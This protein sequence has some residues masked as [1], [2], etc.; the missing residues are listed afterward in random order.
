MSFPDRGSVGTDA[1]FDVYDPTVGAV[2][3]VDGLTDFEATVITA[4]L[5]WHGLNGNDAYAYTYRGWS[6]TANY[7]RLNGKLDAYFA[8]REARY[9]SGRALQ[10]VT[11]V[12]TIR[13][14]DGSVSQYRFSKLDLKQ[15]S[16]GRFNRDD[17]VTGTIEGRAGLRE[18]I[19]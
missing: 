14:E 16:S 3:A 6:F 10:T 9:R 2:V 8:E 15:S 5:E 7:D 4:D 13:E 11:I 19:A 18:K 17:K 1:S 12:Q